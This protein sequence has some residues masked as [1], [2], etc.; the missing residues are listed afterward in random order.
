MHISSKVNVY[1][2]NY[3]FVLFYAIDLKRLFSLA[4]NRKE[5][6]PDTFYDKSR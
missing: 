6:N 2:F 5:K 4:R 3:N 1:G